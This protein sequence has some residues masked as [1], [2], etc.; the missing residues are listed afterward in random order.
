MGKRQL[1]WG[2]IVGT[3][4]KRP[5]KQKGLKAQL[6]LTLGCSSLEKWRA[7]DALSREVDIQTESSVLPRMHLNKRN[8]LSVLKPTSPQ[9]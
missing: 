9:G 8:G 7:L 1:T 5:R 3:D 2:K 4:V 6:H